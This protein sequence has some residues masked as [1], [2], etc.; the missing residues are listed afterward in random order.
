MPPDFW[1]LAQTYALMAAIRTSPTGT[2]VPNSAG[3]GS[4]RLTS[5]TGSLSSGIFGVEAAAADTMKV[6]APMQS[7]VSV[8]FMVVFSECDR[9]CAGIDDR[10]MLRRSSPV[11]RLWKKFS[12]DWMRMIG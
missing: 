2:A 6:A 10:G 1:P 4:G 12:W 3:L 8:G 5:V 11:K 7:R 9:A